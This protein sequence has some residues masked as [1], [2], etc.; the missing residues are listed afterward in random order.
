MKKVLHTIILVLLQLAGVTAFAQQDTPSSQSDSFNFINDTTGMADSLY[1][2]SIYAVRYG[3]RGSF[4]LLDTISN[5]TILTSVFKPYTTIRNVYFEKKHV[6]S[7]LP[8][9]KE[10]VER[11][12]SKEQWKF[13]V[14]LFVILYISF[15]R[16]SNPNNFRVFILSV[17][18]LKL[19]K[20]IWEDQRSFFGF[21]ILQLFAIYLFI[22]AIFITNWM[23]TKNALYV[24]N[25]F[26][27]FVIVLG[28]LLVMYM[29]KFVLHAFMSSLFQMRNLGVGLISNVISVN[30]FIAL[31]IFPFIIFLIYTDQVLISK[32]LSQAIISIFLLSILYRL[33]RISLLSSSFFSFPRIYLFLYLC[34][35]EI[36]P[37]FVIVKYINTLQV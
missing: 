9:V 12:V 24:D 13:W 27:Q 28:G 3:Q 25:Y 20:K 6:R 1:A 8:T 16:I 36:A 37:W 7:G 5:D 35:L 4:G 29:L 18:N 22:A 33:V 19:S 17:F 14:I 23:E 32:V 2:D 15:V 30:N 26:F 11:P 34:A 10:I 31:V 21:V